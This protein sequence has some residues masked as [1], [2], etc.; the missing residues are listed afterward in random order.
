MR[1]LVSVNGQVSGPMDE[2]MTAGLVKAGQIA[3]DSLL[4][5]ESGVGWVPI[6]QTPFGSLVQAPG[7]A[8]GREPVPA[9]PTVVSC[10]YAL[11]MIFV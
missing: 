1:W 3:P 8:T 4:R 2:A 9:T 10:V 7:V 6:V 11:V 5:E